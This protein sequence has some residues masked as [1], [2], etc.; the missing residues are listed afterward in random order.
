MPTTATPLP[1]LAEQRRY[2]DE[3]WERQRLPNAYQRRRGDALLAMLQTLALPDPEI[4]D[5]GCGTGWFTAD[6][7]R[8]GRATGIDLSAGAIATARAA[9][10]HVSF[11]AANALE[12]ALPAEHFDV[13]VSQEVVAHIEDPVGYLELIARILKPGGY[14]LITSANPRVI[15]HWSDRGP[16]YSGHIK[17]FLDRRAFTWML[18]RSFRVL[19]VT[20]I[21]PVGDL[22]LH[23]IWNSNRLATALGWL[24]SR[25]SLE[26]V[27]G[28]AG[29]GYTL[30]AL[31]RKPA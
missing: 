25:A 14:L 16:D 23:R 11:I 17:L 30:I 9:Y 24:V 5:L 28:W 21:M 13:V 19:R 29:L 6:L 3:R 10:P 31:A 20:S 1:S 12:T 8:L 27:K 2:W 15:A 4:L 18:R 22:G 7:C 26:R